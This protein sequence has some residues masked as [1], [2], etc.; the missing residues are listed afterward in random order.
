[1]V[2]EDGNLLDEFFDQSLIKLCYVGFLLGDEVLQLLD[3]VHGLFPVVAVNF[4][5]FPL[6]PE[7]ENLIG[8]GVV[9]LLVICLL[10]K[11][12][13]QFFQPSLDAIRREGVG[14]DHG[15]GDI[16]LQLFQEGAA[17]CQN[18]IDGIDRDI[19]QQ[20][21]VYR[22]IGAVCICG[23]RFQSADAAPDDGL[24]TVVVPVDTPVKL[25]AV[26]AEN[27]LCKTVIA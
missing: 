6:L 22:P 10:D 17:L 3:P 9:V 27:H 1:M 12:F 7:A 14:A 18:L 8:D 20:E 16:G 11:L 25:A 23:A 19:L 4:G 24:A 5:L 2:V 21:L 15:L 13:L 26:S